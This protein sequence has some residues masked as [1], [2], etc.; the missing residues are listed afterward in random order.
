MRVCVD[1]GVCRCVGGCMSV[2]LGVCVCV[3]GCVY[4][5]GVWVRGCRYAGVCVFM[6]ACMLSKHTYTEYIQRL[7]LCKCTHFMLCRHQCLPTY[8]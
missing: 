8:M 1:V 4:Y 6:H 5:V 7:H 3:G 2:Y